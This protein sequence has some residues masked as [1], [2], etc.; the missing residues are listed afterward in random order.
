MPVIMKL[1]GHALAGPM[2]RDGQYL[3]AFDIEAHDGRGMIDMTPDPAL[4]MRFDDMRAAWEYWR[5][6]PKCHPIRQSDG[7]PN[8]PL[9]AWNWEFMPYQPE[10][11]KNALV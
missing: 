9:T 4:A 6:S 10:E 8:R 7:K 3:R 11:P 2:P 5:S 1:C